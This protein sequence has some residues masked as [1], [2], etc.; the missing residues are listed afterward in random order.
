LRSIER[1]F[2]WWDC[3]R[4]RTSSRIFKDLRRPNHW[5]VRGLTDPKDFFLDFGERW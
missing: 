5:H 2:S 4:Q 3:M 1:F